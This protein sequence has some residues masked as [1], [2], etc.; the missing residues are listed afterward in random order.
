MEKPEIKR[1]GDYIISAIDM[2]ESFA[3]GVYRDYTARKNW[4]GDLDSE[5]FMKIQSLLK[6]LINDTEKHK[7]ILTQLKKKIVQL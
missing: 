4:P 1:I 5:T 6:I 3:N 7:N 2:E